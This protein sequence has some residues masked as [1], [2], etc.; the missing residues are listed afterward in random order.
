[1]RRFFMLV[2]CA[3]LLGMSSLQAQQIR[4]DFDVQTEWGPETALGS[5]F[6]GIG[7]EPA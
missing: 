4:G 7:I 1:M 3:T 2:A 6:K 5:T